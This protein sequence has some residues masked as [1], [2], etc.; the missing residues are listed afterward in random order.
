MKH[1]TSRKSSTSNNSQIGQPAR[2]RRWARAAL[3]TLVVALGVTPTLTTDTAQAYQVNGSVAWSGSTGVGTSGGTASSTGASALVTTVTP[4]GTAVKI[5]NLTSSPGGTYFATAAMFTPSIVPT[6]PSVQVLVTEDSCGQVVGTCT[7]LGSMTLSFNRPVTNPVLH[8][9]GLGGGSN[10]T[11]GTYFWSSIGTIISS[12]PASPLPTFGAVSAGSTNL[13]ATSAAFQTSTSLANT[14]CDNTTRAGLTGATATAGCGSL[15][16]IGTFSSVTIQL[17]LKI[18]KVGAGT[19]TASAGQGDAFT[20]N[21]TVPEDFGDAPASYDPTAAASH[22][23]GDLKL[24][25]TV[26]Q[27]NA[28]VANGGAVTPSPIANATASSDSDDGVAL[29]TLDTSMIGGT[30]TVPVTLS[31]ASQ[32]GQVCGWVDFNRNGVF[33]T[34]TERACSAFAIA[35][36]SASLAF[37]V[38]ATAAGPTFARFRASYNV[39]QSQNPTGLA[40]S[41]E[42][43]DYQLQIMPAVKIVKALSPAT[44]PGVVN[45]QLGGSTFATNVGNNGTTGFRTVYN[46]GTPD[47]TTATN[48]TTSAVTV[49]AAETAGTS[50]TLTDYTTAY[51]CTDANAAAA[52]SGSGTSFNISIPQTSGT[53]GKAQTVTCTITNTVKPA[54][55]TVVKSLVPA[56]DT[57]KFTLKVGATS[58]ATN[59][60]NAGTGNT[61]VAPRTAVTV[62]EIAGTATNLTSYNSALACTDTA[63]SSAVTITSNTGTS[64]SITP[65]PGQAITCT[66]TNTRGTPTLSVTKTATE[67]S[68]TAVGDVLHYS[69]TVTNTGNQSVSAVTLTDANA[70]LGICTPA[71]PATLAVGASLTCPATHTVVVGDLAGSY[72]NTATANATAPD[73]SAITAS[74]SVTTPVAKLTVTKT[75][76]QSSFKAVGDVLTYTITVTNSGTSTVT[77]ATVTDPNATLGTCTPALPVASLAVGA[78]ISC[79]AAHTVVAGDLAGSYTNTAT[80]TATGPGGTTATAS[81]AVTTPVAKL[82]VV[83]TSSDSVF[84]AVGDVLH[85]TITVTNTGT[86]AVT[87]ATVTDANA[88]L[89]TCTPAIP[90]AS[91]AVNGTISCAATHTVVTGDLAGPYTN[92]ASASATA[93]GGGTVTASGSVTTAIGKL[94]LTKTSPTQSFSAIGDTITYTI[95]ATNTGTSTVTNATVTD[96]GAVLGTCT[97]AIPVASLA[98]GATITCSATHTVTAGDLAGSYTNTASVSATAG[99][100]STVTASG[101]TTTPVAKVSLTKTSSSPTFKA[102]GDVLNYTIVLTNSGTA[103]VTNATISDADAVLGTCTPAVPVASLAPGATVSCSAAHTIVAAD[104]AGSY[105]NSASGSVTT[106]EGATTGATASAVT[107]VSK[108]TVTKTSSTASFK[109]TGDVINYTI[110]VTNSGTAPLSSVGVTDVDAVLGTCTPAIPVASLAPAATISCAASHTVVAGDL[111]GSYTNTATASA[112]MLGGGSISGSGSV[113]TPVAKL[114]VT[115]TAADASFSVVGDVVHYTITISNP[116]TATLTSVDIADANAVVSACSPA[117]PLASLAPGGTVS[118]SATHTIVAADLAGT[119]A[120]TATATATTPAGPAI[121][122]S[123][124]TTTP[125]AKLIVAKTAT[126]ATFTAVGEVIHYSITITNTGTAP[127]SGVSLSDPRAVVGTCTPSLPAAT[128]A[129]G[130]AISCSATHTVVSADLAG[131]YTNTA[132]A[133]ATSP[134][135]A[136][137]GGSSSVTTPLSR[138]SV[139]KTATEQSFQT[140]GEVLHYS[141]TAT[142][143]GTTTLTSVSINDPNASLGSCTPSAPVASLAPGAS[144]SC[145]ATHTIVA[146]DLS[147]SYLNTAAVNGTGPGPTAVTALGSVSVPFARL[148]VTKTSSAPSFSAVGDTIDYTI[149]VANTGTATVTGITVTDPAANLGSCSPSVPTTLVAGATIACAASHTVSAAD[150]GGSYTNTATASGTAPGGASVSA[151]GS[152]DVPLAKVSI[153]KTAA[154]QSFVALGDVVHYSIVVTNNGTAPLTGATVADPNAVVSSCSPTIPAPLAIGATI[155]CSATHTVVAADMS[156]RQIV[157]TATTTATA[158]SGASVTASSTTTTPLGRL[159]LTKSADTSSFSKEGDILSFTIVATNTGLAPLTNMSV[160]DP[161]AV[162]GSCSPAIPVAILAPGSAVVCAATHT[163]VAGDVGSPYNNTATGSA[164]APGG[165]AVTGSAS[166][167]TPYSAL[168]VVKTSSAASFRFVGDVLD[169]T[170]VVTN[171]GSA[172]LTNVTVSDP[173]ATLGSCSPAIPVAALAPGASISCTASHAVTAGDIG[174]S[175]VNTATATAT[176]PGGSTLSTDHAVTVPYAHLSLAKTTA[177]T[178]SPAAGSVLDYTIV[179]TND[180]TAT[181]TGVDITDSNASIVGCTPTIPVTGLVPGASVTCT[182]THTTTLAEQNA[183]IVTNTAAA[184][185]TA[186]GGASVTASDTVQT[187]A[188]IDP[189]LTVTKTATPGTLDSVGD[190]VDFTIQVVND[191]NVSIF[192]VDVTDANATLGSCTPVRPVPTLLPGGSISCAASHTV[193]QADLDAGFV[194]NSAHAAGTAPLGASVTADG[195]TTAPTLRQPSL[196]TVKTANVSSVSASGA[197]IVYTITSTNSGNV[198]LTNVG[199]SDAGAT[200]GGCSPAQPVTSLAPGQNVTCTAT[201]TVSQ[202]DVDSGLVANVAT[203][204]ADEPGGGTVT[205]SGNVQTP[206]V[207]QPSLSATKTP[208]TTN[209]ITVGANVV[210]HIVVRNTGNVTL[211]GVGVS[212][213][214]AVIGACTPAAPATLAPDATIECDATHT[215]TQADLDGG[216]VRNTASTSGTSPTGSTVTATSAEAQVPA[217]Q[218]PSLAASKSSATAPVSAVGQVITYTLHAANTGNVTLSVVSMSD[219]NAVIGS[220]T[221][222]LPVTALAPGSAIDCAATHV[223]TQDDLDGGGVS[224]VVDAHGL[225]TN[226]GPVQSSSPPVVVSANQRPE[227]TTVKSTTS[228]TIA[229][230]GDVVEYTIIATNTGNVTLTAATVTDANAVLDGCSPTVPVS[231][232]VPG[233]SVTCTAHHVT[234]QADLDLGHVDNVAT[235]AAKDPTNVI[236]FD[237]SPPTVVLVGQVAALTTVK[238]S[239]T[240]G[241]SAVGGIITYEVMVTNSGNVTLTGLTVT[242]ANAVLGTCSPT[243]PVASFGPRDTVTCSA[244]HAVTQADLD[245]GHYDNRA[246]ASATDPGTSPV[247]ADSTLIVVPATQSPALTT[248]K[249]TTTSTVSAPGDPVSYSIVVTNSGNVTLTNVSVSDANAVVGACST[250]LPVASLAPGATFNC[251]ATHATTQA[252]LDAGDVDNIAVASATSP[253]GNTVTDD[254]PNV[255]VGATRS[256]QLT[257]TKST[258]TP[259]YSAVGATMAYTITVTNSGNV[260]VRNVDVTDANAVISSCTS[261][262]PVPSIAPGASVS[263]SAA[264]VVTQADLDAGHYDNVAVG[265]G[266]D[267]VSGPVSGNS[268]IVTVNAAQSPTLAVTK[269]SPTSSFWV[270]GAP[271]DYTIGVT[272]VGNVTVSAVSVTDANA[273]IS[274]CTPATPVTTLAPGQSISCTASHAATQADIDA[275]FYGNVAAAAATSPTGGP[276]SASS[277][278]VNVNA[279]QAPA[280]TTTKTSSTPS[281]SAVGATLSY[282]ITTTNSGNV[283]L[284]NVS[285]S[286]ANAA[287]GSCSP[288]TPVASLPPG[289]SVTCSA[290]HTVT[291][292]D[293]DAGHYDNVA[294]ATGTRPTGG[295]VSGDSPAVTANAVQSPS[296]TTTKSSSTPSYAAVGGSIVYAIETTNTGNVTLTAVSVTDANATISSCTPSLPVPSLAPGGTISCVAAHT[297]TQVDLDAGHVDN[298][299]SSAGTSPTGGAVTHDSNTSRVNAVQAPELTTTKTSSAAS[300]S[301]V[302]GTIDY[303]V[304]VTNSGNVTLTAVSVSDTNAALGPC[305]PTLPVSTLAPGG[306]ITC[307]ASHSVT[308]ADLDA[309]HYDNVAAASATSPTGGAVSGDSPTVT[310]NAT[311]SPELTTTK[312]S[313]TVSFA[314][315]GGTIAYSITATNTG[316]VTLTNVSITDASAVVQSCTPASPATLVPGAS[317]SCTAGHVVTQ[318][319]LDAGHYD[320]LASASG[321]TPTGG[322]VNDDS[323][324]VTVNAIQNGSLITTKSSPTSTYSTVGATITYSITATN[325]GNVTLTSVSVTDANATISSCT[326][327]SPVASLAPGGAISC[328]TSHTV[329]QADLDADHYDNVATSSGT[330]PTGLAVTGSSTSVRVNAAQSPSLATTK[331]TSTTSYALVGDVSDYTIAVR[332]SGNVTLTNVQVIDSDA[333][334]SSCTPTTPVASLAPG[335]SIA[336]LATHTATQADLDAGHHDN[337]ASSTGVT[338]G[339]TTATSFSATIRVNAVQSAALTTTKTTSST[340]Y[341]VVGALIDYSIAAT[342]SGNVTLT[343]VSVSDPK[344]VLGSCT[345]VTPVASLAPGASISCTAAHTVTQADL[346]AGH[347]DNI[348]TASGTSPTGGPVSGGSSTITVN[349]AQSAELTTTKSS[350]TTSYVVVGDVIDY[351]I[352]VANSGNVTLS[353]VSVT[354]V[355]ATVSSCTPTTPVASLAPGGSISCSASHTVTQA[356]ID[357]GHYD[358]IASASGTS[359]TSVA[360]SD[361]SPTVAV[362]AATGPALTTTKSTTATSFSTVGAVI[363]YTIGVRNSGNQTLTAVSVTDDNAVLGSC[364]PSSPVGSL[365]PGGVISCSASH[366]VTQTDLDAGYVSNVASAAG[367]DPNGDAVSN[368]SSTVTVNAVQSPALTTTK[369]STS[370]AGYLAVGDVLGYSITAT[371]SGNVTLTAVTVTDANATISSCTPALPVASLAPGGSISCTAAHTVTQADLDAGQYDNIASASGTDP[372]TVPVSDDSPMVTRSALQFPVLTVSKSSSTVSY[373]AVGDTVSYTVDV[374]NSG[375]VTLSAVSV[376]DANATISSCTPTMPVAVFAPAASV[377]CTAT[378]TVTQADLD[379]G[380]VD[381]VALATATGPS[382]AVAGNSPVVAVN[383]VQSPQLTTTKTSPTLS[384]AAVGDTISYTIGVSNSGNV[385][386]TNVS[387]TD[388]NATVSSCTPTIPVASLA[389]GGSISCSASH[390]VTLADLNAGHYDN[391]AT[392]TGR[393]PTGGVVFDDSPT[394]TANAVQTP[395]LTTTKSTST[396]NYSTVGATIAYTIVA[397]NSGNVTLTAVTVTDA[398]AVLGS[399]TPTIPV[400]SLAP[401]SSISCTASH[402]IVQADV[403][404]AHYD[405]LATASGT[406]PTGGPVTADSPTVTVNAVQTPQ[407]TTIKTSST[408]SYSTVGDTISYTITATNTGNVTLTAVTVTDANA[409]LGSCTPTGPASLI[410]GAAVTC[411]ATH[412]VTQVDLDAGHVDNIATASGTDPNTVPVSDDSPTITINAVQSP[413]LTTTKT[414]STAQFS[415]VGDAINYTITATNSGNVTLT[416]VSVTDANAVI[417]SCSPSTPATI[418]PGSAVTCTATH[419]VTQ[420]DI[421]SGPYDNVGS[422]S[423]ASPAGIIVS[424]DSSTVTVPGTATAQLTTTK[425]SSTTSYSTV[426]GVINYTIT[427]TNSGTVTFTTVTVTD[428]NATIG[429]CT[430]AIPLAPMAPAATI[431]CSATH[432][433]TQ[434]DL[435]TGHYDNVAS[436]TGRKANGSLLRADSPAVT[437]NAAQSPSLAVAKTA[438]TTSVSTVGAAAAFTVVATNSGNVTLTNVTVTD[439]NATV[440]TCTPALPVPT[441]APGATVS[442]NVSHPATQADLDAGHVDNVASAAATPPVGATVTATSPTA[443]VSAAQAPALTTVKTSSTPNVS[444]VGDPIAY[445][446]TATNSGNVTVNSVTVTD[447]NATLGTCTPA[448]PVASLA[449]GSSVSCAATHI[450][451]QTDLD[452][453]SVLNTADA[454]AIAPSGATVSDASPVVTVPV[455]NGPALTTTK[456]TTS[457]PVS[458]VGAV[459]DYSITVTNTGNTTLTSVTMTDPTATVG[460][461]TPALPVASLAPGAGVSCTASHAVT[462]ADLDAGTLVNTAS[463]SGTAPGGAIVTSPDARVTTNVDQAPLLSLKK[464]AALRETKADNIGQVGESIDYTLVVRNE[465]NVT[466]KAARVD[467]PMLTSLSCSIP[468]PTDLAPGGTFTCTGTHLIGVSDIV[469]G[470]VVNR[471][472]AI[473][474]GSC[475]AGVVCTATVMDNAVAAIEATAPALPR[476]GLAVDRQLLWA[477]L[478]TL[479]GVVMLMLPI[480]RRRRQSDLPEQAS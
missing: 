26:T 94:A 450:V 377:S 161:S 134:A 29:P 163:V 205:S 71:T 216:R 280:L 124:A 392:A 121:A 401:G 382:G 410:P 369:S 337:T 49:A 427:V 361:G 426:G 194:S 235:A 140:V 311:Q 28:T 176:E 82:A 55:I 57:G 267:P 472:S 185:G 317:V 316:N 469:A 448:L 300:Y 465:G 98:A 58:V 381:N 282:S 301:A 157:N 198:T 183:G 78:S 411:G 262:R 132:T 62:S 158:P 209:Y 458:Q 192:G 86:T 367:A 206:A 461:C 146:G 435:D 403:D 234:T 380:H 437:V 25:S 399:C 357:A 27:E 236:V 274:S 439:A 350:P 104:L 428:A 270:V 220:C 420:V 87:N 314:A 165:A 261:A 73:G 366:T 329:T 418:A 37:T 286:D 397:T 264:H 120:N 284:T 144:I 180:G 20:V 224:N 89:G 6:T 154:E 475:A 232:L 248:T 160:T 97:P 128:L 195:S 310:V 84:S 156:A 431:S 65:T 287:I 365:V 48:I 389:P 449:P 182:A 75:A 400:A 142:N 137:V 66:F 423:G 468:Q 174:S 294:S 463:S 38:P 429:T 278:N 141:I 247:T 251:A 331:T 419:T 289:G 77:N 233:D 275:G 446:I 100:G 39:A 394:V 149:T 330:G 169:F 199:V 4:A 413:A 133:S 81:G 225:D 348:A 253:S 227:L 139:S 373:A 14:S 103:T 342:N 341:A 299:A 43:E 340:G 384:Y 218:Q 12:N 376:T 36:T 113:S 346:D 320:N 130:D 177:S 368:D 395:Q 18:A 388:A 276:V 204:T 47:V 129:A 175:Y 222:S 422:S 312:T 135:G 74:G 467:D 72:T 351:S 107:P 68:F 230:V 95:T 239:S 460:S 51:A 313:S 260:T 432:T 93:P 1:L 9:A 53:N 452:A 127:L 296:L 338:A 201:R 123:G 223:V 396:V 425:S 334:I 271:I 303:T 188:T 298:V 17:D 148:S 355:N 356:D 184:T 109:S 143:I 171:G 56:A 279:Q 219:P 229:A 11:V 125:V 480:G 335:G 13:T 138:L 447:A 344:A 345:P 464:T 257:T 385:T 202:A 155:T 106:P 118:C 207:R 263:C 390:T 115:K 445:V 415:A 215:A 131:G 371:N 244:S 246:T 471:A 2:T 67:S 474:T 179:L 453:G 172:P 393:N 398:N 102:V 266:N 387:V 228:T 327:P 96:A 307:A 8:L 145:T 200:L 459:V 50:S 292:A 254:S 151:S 217:V 42:V 181:L 416:N 347:Y 136:A 54:T 193:T 318:A 375:N 191:G 383:A 466:V 442:C 407:L 114:S 214:N 333:V 83:K 297:V 226:G 424:N 60:G 243:I 440:G 256:P 402:T 324:T 443:S 99:N 111:A 168:V 166:A 116:G 33:E 277:A 167:A 339:G 405:N 255:S 353:A 242:D 291:L 91:L 430:P 105:T 406:P 259:N 290:S 386:V 408:A 325:A 80:A 147:G 358:N 343:N 281:Y 326:P 35:A 79:A 470:K 417:G 283:T 85:Y 108:I 170:I 315:V 59:V 478:A 265:T 269:S 189:H 173:R 252:E 285:V 304:V 186:P 434:A 479:L 164:T 16:L 323:P 451:T 31:G 34:A 210:F 237:D 112:T 302:G 10:V 433:V 178:V 153:T 40:D 152:V 90:V 409:I 436:A 52:G 305:T 332:N 272:N 293:L 70:S 258:P 221:P 76:G 30:Y 444:A 32:A 92:T 231:R 476:T 412:T 308:Q 364:S 213:T 110:T 354:D 328:S 360:V 19:G 24:G 7:G 370:T 162:V 150:L 414:S 457:G 197:T 391:I 190:V 122:A 249:T 319:N 3:A 88:V 45:L 44:D 15:P 372:N 306:A 241:Y 438:N 362:N 455:A 21:V 64:G 378:H 46:S 441:L 63:T 117:V 456:S 187:P 69:I 379:A 374:V 352:A 41:G 126:E 454:S 273:V 477:A 322:S 321:T 212:D 203:A 196:D 208:V 349:A 5:N 250:T 336:C 363:T 101:S 295:T 238:S 268:P 309:G 473:G 462:Q 211:T 421:D 22:I 159:T 245:A 119:Y 404:A 61:T 288:T 240:T 359:P 23:I